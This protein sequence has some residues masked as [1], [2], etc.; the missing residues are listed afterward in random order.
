MKKVNDLY[1]LCAKGHATV[2]Q[3]PRT[4]CDM[5]IKVMKLLKKGSEVEREETCGCDVVTTKEMPSE[6]T[7]DRVWNVQEIEAFLKGQ[8]SIGPDFI[9][10]VQEE[11]V[12]I[13]R[14][15]N[16]GGK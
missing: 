16:E 2:G 10:S 12:K 4:K 7:F 14:A 3:N 8:Q 13:Q 6:L 9:R 1:F 11:F 15:L 5:K